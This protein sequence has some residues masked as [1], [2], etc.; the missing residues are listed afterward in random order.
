MSSANCRC[1]LMWVNHSTEVYSW[2]LIKL[3]LDA[4]H[5]QWPLEEIKVSFDK[6]WLLMT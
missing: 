1:L 2:S 5:Y 6:R 3:C 4:S